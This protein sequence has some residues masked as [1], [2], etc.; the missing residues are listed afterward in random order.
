MRR[1]IVHWGWVLVLLGLPLTAS[2]H[3]SSV[4]A[5][6]FTPHPLLQAC[7]AAQRRSPDDK[8]ISSD[9]KNRTFDQVI[10]PS[11]QYEQYNFNLTPAPDA[12][13]G[14]LFPVLAKSVAG[15]ESQWLQYRGTPEMTTR[16]SDPCDY[17]IMQIN[18]PSNTALFSNTPS[19]LSRTD[20]NIAAGAVVL[21]NKWNLGNTPSLPVVNDRDPERLINWYY[22]SAAYNAAPTANWRNNPNC[23]KMMVTLNCGNDYNYTTSRPQPTPQNLNPSA[24]WDT[25]DPSDFPYQERVLYN[26]QYP[27]LP[28]DASRLFQVGNLGLKQITMPGDYGIRPDDSLFPTDNMTSSAPDLLLFRHRTATIISTALT[29]QRLVIE[30]DLPRMANV[31]IDLLDANGTFQTNLLNNQPRQPGWYSESLLVPIRVST[32]WKYRIRAETTTYKGLYVQ[33]LVVVNNPPQLYLPLVIGGNGT[34]NLLRNGDFFTVARGTVNEA[35]YWELQ[36][37]VRAGPGRSGAVSGINRDNGR[38]Q[39]RAGA[40]TNA[41]D[42]DPTRRTYASRG[43]ITQRVFADQGCYN[44]GFY[45]LSQDVA[46]GSKLLARYRA[47]DSADWKMITEV[48]TSSSS[49]SAAPNITISGPSIV[50]FLATFVGGDTTTVFEIDDVK[51]QKSPNSATCP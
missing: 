15:V 1:R 4:Q 34:N 16:G 43:E 42:P 3:G 26:L 8:V 33:N 11:D 23:G 49:G 38:F 18:Y 50:S 31:T 25:L 28:S 37:V 29:R 40:A 41:T 30:Y 6:P 36:T 47:I 2:L 39:F 13:D 51:L 21:K 10:T 7:P 14:S 9:D 27:K 12:P 5:A 45:Y 22:A 20:G 44:I 46:A 17:G 48:T 32:G 19:L 24:D 35:D